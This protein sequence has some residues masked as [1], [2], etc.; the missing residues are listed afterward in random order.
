MNSAFQAV[1]LLYDDGVVASTGSLIELKTNT[2]MPNRKTFFNAVI[3]VCNTCQNDR[4]KILN[5]I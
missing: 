4:I 3:L 5:L 1:L 2:L